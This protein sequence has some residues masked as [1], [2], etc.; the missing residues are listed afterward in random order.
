MEAEKANALFLLDHVS[1]SGARGETEQLSR[2]ARRG[3]SFDLVREASAIL[4]R[5]LTVGEAS[6]LV[7]AKVPLC[8]PLPKDAVRA[9]LAIDPGASLQD[10]ALLAKIGEVPSLERI[11]SKLTPG[12]PRRDRAAEY[13]ESWDDAKAGLT[14]ADRIRIDLLLDLFRSAAGRKAV[15]EAISAD[16]KQLDAEAGGRID[17]LGGEPILVLV[18]SDAA[19]NNSYVY[20]G[21]ASALLSSLVPFHLHAI[22]EAGNPSSAGPS[23]AWGGTVGDRAAARH[24]GLA[25]VVITHLDRDRFG[26]DYYTPSGV[27][28]DLGTFWYSR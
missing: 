6:M 18:P 26:V 8:D 17:L 25:E 11:G 12:V 27:V 2:A 28:V 23:S 24:R 19:N 10:V 20:P 15:S 1:L 13:S 14:K 5:K 7:T 9:A 4:G 16:L 22:D 21:E 3:T